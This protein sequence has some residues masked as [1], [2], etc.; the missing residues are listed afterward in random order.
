M[1]IISYLRGFT[2]LFYTRKTN[3]KVKSAGAVIAKL[4]SRTSLYTCVDE[5]IIPDVNYTKWLSVL[6]LC[7]MLMQQQ[8]PRTRNIE[9]GKKYNIQNS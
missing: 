4:R 3:G 7:Q 6:W 1:L 8:H 5:I 9:M 2:A